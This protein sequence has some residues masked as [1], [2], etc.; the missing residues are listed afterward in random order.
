MAG[1]YGC[2]GVKFGQPKW[3][4]YV[5]FLVGFKKL[6]LF[7]IGCFQKWKLQL[8]VNKVSDNYKTT[9]NFKSL[10]LLRYNSDFRF[11][12]STNS[13][14]HPL[15]N[16]DIKNKIWPIL[17]FEISQMS[18]KL[19]FNLDFLELTIVDPVWLLG[20]TLTSRLLGRF[21][22]IFL[23]FTSN[24]WSSILWHFKVS[25]DHELT[26]GQP[27]NFSSSCQK[28]TKNLQTRHFTPYINSLYKSPSSRND[29]TESGGGAPRVYPA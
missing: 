10:K 7:R 15:S 25:V 1:R 21:S 24:N 20:K 23:C 22:E 5:P 13:Y 18:H 17:N 8:I 9:I 19:D 27:V 29:N 14:W 2:K 12:V 26:S 16:Y 11:F 3:V 28:Y 4:C 6:K